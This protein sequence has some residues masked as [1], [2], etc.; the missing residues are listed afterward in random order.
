MIK[1]VNREARV[2]RFKPHSAVYVNTDDCYGPE[3][4]LPLRDALNALTGNDE[5]EV[6]RNDGFALALCP[7]KQEKILIGDGCAVAIG[8]DGALVVLS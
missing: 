3:G 4:S 2:E 6:Y 8:P 5:A 1:N 7:V